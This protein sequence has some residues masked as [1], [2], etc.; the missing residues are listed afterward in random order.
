M[1]T[2]TYRPFS[3]NDMIGQ[4]GI[5]KEMKKRS[6]T[7][8]FPEVMIFEGESGT[9]KSTIA[10]IIAA[11]INDKN[12]IINKDKTKD[13]NPESPSSKSVLEER[14]NRDII[15]YDASSM[16]KEDVLNL[17]KSVNNA[18]MFDSNRVIIIDEAQELT[19]A[20]KG[21]TLDLLEKKR[22][23]CYFILCTMNINAFDKAV[24]SRGQVYKFKAPTSEDIAK[25]LFDYAEKSEVSMEDH[26]EF[27][28]QVIFS[29]AENCEGSVRM[30]IQNFERCLYGEIFTIDEFEKEF[31]FISKDKLAFLI[32][33]LVDKDS[34]VLQDIK[35][36]DSKDFYYKTVKTLTEAFV[37]H[38]TGYISAQWKSFLAN[39]IDKK[40]TEDLLDLLLKVDSIGYFKEDLFFYYLAKFIKKENVKKILQEEPAKR[41]RVPIK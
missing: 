31:S 29:L 23:N 14:F 3:F 5:L 10:R 9:G 30:A 19:K 25:L 38:Q 18:P 37:F 34:S 28:S 8:D 20:G 33:K 39:S 2:Q 36:F 13:P 27:Y 11:L 17:S 40:N 24:R 15:H 21:V 26:E 6:K 35:N 4:N 32:K 12:P 41:K 16:G 22:K 1:L 7:M